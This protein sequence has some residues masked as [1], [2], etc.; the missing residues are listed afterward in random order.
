MFPI[1]SKNSVLK[2]EASS[3]FFFSKWHSTMTY[4]CECLLWNTHGLCRLSLFVIFHTAECNANNHAN[5]QIN[6]PGL[7]HGGHLSKLWCTAWLPE[8][9][10]WLMQSCQSNV[11]VQFSLSI[12]EWF[13]IYRISET[14]LATLRKLTLCYKGLTHWGWDKMEAI[15]R[16][17]VSNGFSWIKNFW[18]SIKIS[19]KF[20]TRGPIKQYHSIGLDDGLAPTRWQAIIWSSDG[21]FTDSYM[22]H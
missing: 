15:F 14:L 16:T 21:Q 12:A 22:R 2:L 8:T 4:L 9:P 10:D 6:I 3:L 19:M 17:T 1:S 7:Y 18:I 5:M 11:T 20:V 13:F